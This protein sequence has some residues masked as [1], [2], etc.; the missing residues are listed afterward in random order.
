MPNCC[1]L[2]RQS[3]GTVRSQLPAQTSP[4]AAASVDSCLPCFQKQCCRRGAYSQ[5]M[6][7]FPHV[8]GAMRKGSG[9]WRSLQAQGTALHSL[10]SFVQHQHHPHCTSRDM[11]KVPAV[12][13]SLRVASSRASANRSQASGAGCAQ[14]TA[15]GSSAATATL[16]AQKVPFPGSACSACSA[17]RCPG[18]GD[19]HRGALAQIAAEIQTG[20]AKKEHYTF[21]RVW[22]ISSCDPD[23]RHS[24]RRQAIEA[25]AGCSRNGRACHPETRLIHTWAEVDHKTLPKL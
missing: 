23:R 10:P 2:S 24:Q 25:V 3:L 20:S 19:F 5:R 21:K 22:S 16:A 14:V 8:E 9:T 11:C 6:P 15:W 4:L 18:S 17:Q 13:W 1:S 12:P 7:A